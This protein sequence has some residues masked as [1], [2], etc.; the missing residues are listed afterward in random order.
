MDVEHELMMYV[1]SALREFS[2]LP[3]QVDVTPRI[4]QLTTQIGGFRI[5][6]L[7]LQHKKPVTFA[8]SGLSVCVFA[9]VYLYLA[10]L[11][12][13]TYY[14]LARVQLLPYDW[15]SALVTSLFIPVA[16]DDIPNNVWLKLL[17]GIHWFAVVAFGVGALFAYFHKKLDEVYR[18]AA[19]VSAKVEA[20]D[21]KNRLSELELKMKAV[22][23]PKDIGQRVGS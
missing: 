19:Y 20:P 16:Y 5:A 22:S 3:I 23:A 11:F 8:V 18:V 14:G 9:V 15:G 1:D 21:I 4:R 17:G 2:S 13:F 12:S 7:I 6:A 10:V